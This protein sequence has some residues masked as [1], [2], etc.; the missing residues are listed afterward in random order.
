MFTLSVSLRATN[1]GH[2]RDMLLV[3]QLRYYAEY[4]FA[5]RVRSRAVPLKADLIQDIHVLSNCDTSL[6]NLPFDIPRN[7]GLESAYMSL[8]ISCSPCCPP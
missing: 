8:N 4:P 5:V 7:H 2:I 3:T 1:S 6:E